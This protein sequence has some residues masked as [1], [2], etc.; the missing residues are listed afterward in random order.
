[1]AAPLLIGAHVAKL[2]AWDLE[3]YSNR[4][5]IAVNQDI[6]ATQGARVVGGDLV[7]NATTLQNATNIWARSLAD[8][9]VARES[10]RN[11]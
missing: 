1:M 2:S 9:S 11:K 7:V 5:V 10:I 4:E 8:G 3:T 6:D